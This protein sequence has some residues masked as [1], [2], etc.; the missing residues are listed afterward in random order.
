MPR[1][2]QLL[3][4][5]PNGPE[6]RW[7]LPEERKDRSW[8]C[9][10]ERANHVIRRRR[11]LVQCSQEL[12]DSAP[13]LVVEA[14]CQCAIHRGERISTSL[15]GLDAHGVVQAWRSSVEGCSRARI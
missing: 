12:I 11:Q 7:R 4:P 3:H 2:P 10:G 13:I 5:V 14:R 9:R 8:L 1:D 6:M 15:E